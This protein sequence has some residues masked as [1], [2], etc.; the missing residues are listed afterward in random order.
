MLPPCR[1]FFQTIIEIFH[2]FIPTN[3]SAIQISKYAEALRLNYA[4]SHVPSYRPSTNNERVLLLLTI[5]FEIKIGA[6]R[7]NI[8]MPQA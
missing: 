5:C 8:N 2:T 4:K 6:I 1:K 3:N 7:P